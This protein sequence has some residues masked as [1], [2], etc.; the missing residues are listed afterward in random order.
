MIATHNTLT[1]LRALCPLF[2][3]ASPLW[4]CQDRT[5]TE[6]ICDGVGM[7]D[8]RVV[9]HLGAWRPAHG[10]VTLR[11]DVP[12][13][14]RQIG[15]RPFRIILERGTVDDE[16]AFRCLVRELVDEGR[17]VAAAYIKRGW[18]TVHYNAALNPE[19]R[20]ASYVPFHSNH[21]SWAELWAFLRRPCRPRRWARKHNGQVGREEREA[22]DRVV[23]MDYYELG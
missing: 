11:G 3:L 13:A 7:F 1:Y 17:A 22:K 10:L 6:Q 20:D 4:R 14:I 23:Y 21:F 8:L 2:E 18:R 5:L 12:A 15:P 16:F 19:A 9:R